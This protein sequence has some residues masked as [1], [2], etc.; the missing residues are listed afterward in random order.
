M[1]QSRQEASGDQITVSVEA[2]QQYPSDLIRKL[3]VAV[4]RAV[5]TELAET[6]FGPGFRATDLAPAT[7]EVRAAAGNTNV[8]IIIII[9][10]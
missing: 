4:K 6:D 8:G 9:N 1:S 7:S 5:L 10:T 2:P 3:D